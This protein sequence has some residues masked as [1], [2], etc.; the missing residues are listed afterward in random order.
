[1]ASGLLEI[2][3]WGNIEGCSS[4]CFGLEKF[5]WKFMSRILFVKTFQHR[6]RSMVLG[7][8]FLNDFE[9]ERNLYSV[10][11]IMIIVHCA[12]FYLGIV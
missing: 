1:V 12:V 8:S 3:N 11:Y 5:Q 10:C 4:F 2:L 9:I 7:N 6:R